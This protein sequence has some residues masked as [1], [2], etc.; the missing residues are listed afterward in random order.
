MQASN[1]LRRRSTPR[2]S[3]FRNKQQSNT[4]ARM[5]HRPRFDSEKSHLMKS[6]QHIRDSERSIPLKLTHSKPDRAKNILGRVSSDRSVFSQCMR[7]NAIFTGASSSIFG[8]RAGRCGEPSGSRGISFPNASS[9]RQLSSIVFL[10]DVAR[11]QDM[12]VIGRVDARGR[13]VLGIAAEQSR[14]Y[15]RSLSRRFLCHPLKVCSISAS[16]CRIRRQ[17]VAVQH[18]G[19]RQLLTHRSWANPTC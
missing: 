3:A 13:V 14:K 5:S 9:V 11:S 7:K 2:R 12:G 1:L 16:K 8:M 6:F 17:G 4:V 19:Y 15:T 10:I 18:S